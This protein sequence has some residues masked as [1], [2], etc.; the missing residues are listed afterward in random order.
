YS[1]SFEKGRRYVFSVMQNGIDIVV[2]LIDARGR[3]IAEKDSPNG[4]R[5]FEKL[6]FTADRSGEYRYQIVALEDS[7]NSEVGK[8][9]A[10]LADQ[11][12]QLVAKLDRENR[13]N[14][15]T[16]DIDH[17]WQA[18]DNLKNCR[19]L[20][21]SIMSFQA[22]Y[23]DRATEGFEDFL[24]VR[25]FTSSEYVRMIKTYPKFYR[26]VRMNTLEAKK[27][28]P[29]IEDVFKNFKDLYP[30][31]KP[32]KVNFA[33][34]ALRTAGTVS[35]RY[36][37]IGTEMTT[38]TDQVDLS[39]IKNP[40]LVDILSNKG[41]IAQ[42]LKNI[43]A[44]ECVHTQQVSKLAPDAE[45]CQLLSGI[46]MEGFC[47]FIGEQIAGGQI[48]SVVQEYGDR[49]EKELWQQL[50]S[51]LCNGK[52]EDWL[53]NFNHVKDKP[54]DLGYYMG[55]KIAQSYYEKHQ[56]KKQALIDIIEMNNPKKFLEQ[57]GYADKFK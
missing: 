49:H 35:S 47:D 52:F 38:S 41:D 55:Y 37:L 44:H 8:Y 25:G 30:N 16:L 9:D 26:T 27:A 54:A 36:V 40:A 22:L 43:V 6:S 48:N 24:A 42:S 17:F 3:K 19:S 2:H 50:N 5:G 29:L 12:K 56:D 4:K 15:Q 18:Y 28:A 32:F 39:E 11:D 51:N 21:D 20:K 46:L 45:Q 53:Y 1:V 31:F 14:V 33:I 13:K 57:S 34:G 23:I 10:Y 7:T